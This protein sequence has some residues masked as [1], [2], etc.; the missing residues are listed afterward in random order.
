MQAR[1]GARIRR[2]SRF[3]GTAVRSDGGDKVAR[4]H[5]EEHEPHREKKAHGALHLT[6]AAGRGAIGLLLSP[7]QSIP[8]Q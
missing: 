1:V 7:V 2:T 4:L 5:A 8:K 6:T 3:F